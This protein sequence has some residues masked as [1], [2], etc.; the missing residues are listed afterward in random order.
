MQSE[1][2]SLTGWSDEALVGRVVQRHRAAF[3]V[4]YDRYARLLFGLAVHILGHGDAEEA[5]QEVFV[6]LWVR[7]A[8]YD[9]DRGTFRTWFT[10]L[11]RNQML[12]L[13]KRRA[14]KE[15]K[16]RQVELVDELIMEIAGP[17]GDLLDETWQRQLGKAM[18]SALQKLPPEQRRVILLAY[19]GGYT[20]ARIAQL[21]GWPLGTVKKRLRLGLQKL[22]LDMYRYRDDM[23]P[24]RAG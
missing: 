15:K 8:Q 21:L 13:S 2:T 19:F 5:V 16:F 4:L 18:T 14:V 6:K 9:P 24:D 12:D 3:A 1:P 20:Q 11:A 22:R 7:A 10:A 17:D 23:L